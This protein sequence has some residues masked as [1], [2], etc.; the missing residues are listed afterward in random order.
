MPAYRRAFGRCAPRTDHITGVTAVVC[1]QTALQQGLVS[2][3]LIFVALG[4]LVS[5]LVGSFFGR[6]GTIQAGA[7]LAGAGAAGMLGTSGNLTN[8][9]VCKCIGG[10]G[11]GL[12]IA[13]AGVYGAEC[14]VARYRGMLLALYN[15]GLG[16][17]FAAS[18]AVCWG[19]SS[20]VTSDLSWQIPIICQIPLSVILGLGVL[21]FP[22][23][24]RWL[25]TKGRG[26]AAKKSFAWL[27]AKDPD[28]PDILLQ[29]ADVQNHIQ[30]ERSNRQK[31]QWIEIYQGVNF[32]R[33]MVSGLIMVGLAI[34]GPKFTG[35]YGAVFLAGVGVSNPFLNTF[36]ISLMM[37]AGSVGGPWLVEYGGRRFAMLVGYMIMMVC[38]LTIGSVGSTLGQ[39]TSKARI[40][41]LVFLFLWSFV[42]GLF[43]GT[44]AWIAAPEQHS[45]R[46]RTYGQ[47]STVWIYQVFGFA[48]SFWAP[49]Q[50][51]PQYGNMG[52]SVGYFYAGG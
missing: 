2:L 8:Y 21:A 44:S 3:T 43:I 28:H 51:S 14:T 23:S 4:G 1:S 45:L 19:S 18:S 29:V 27:Y 50:I 49:Y 42:F 12:L 40:V 48:S 32:R 38:M 34:T 22:E 13:A 25:L 30:L 10:V 35:P 17:G 11:L 46:L 6:R 24:P 9:L 36:I 47:A 7:I 41:L 5:G 37:V 15:I 26:E 33:T 52:M 31:T 39:T 20:Y 16:M